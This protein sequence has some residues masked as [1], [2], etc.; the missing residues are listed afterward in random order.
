MM[1]MMM[2][3]V[4]G[5]EQLVV[6]L[7][8]AGGAIGAR[9]GGT[10]A[11]ARQCCCCGRRRCCATTTR[12]RIAALRHDD[13]GWRHA[14]CMVVRHCMSV[15]VAIVVATTVVVGVVVGVIADVGVERRMISDIKCDRKVGARRSSSHDSRVET[16][17]FSMLVAN[18]NVVGIAIKQ[19][20]GLVDRRVRVERVARLVDDKHHRVDDG[21]RVCPRVFVCCLNAER[22][23]TLDEL[24]R[25]ARARVGR[26]RRCR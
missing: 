4:A 26:A 18:S 5:T 19:I 23:A 8:V 2:M 9:R 24:R 10:V 22:V 17:E 25:Y 20:V 3:I 12:G 13:R 11:A 21:R 7:F 14:K 6:L 15:V 16:V 1:M